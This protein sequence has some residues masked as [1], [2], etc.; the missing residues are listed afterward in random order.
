MRYDK[1][2]ATYISK[3][4]SMVPWGCEPQSMP[5]SPISSPR[6][7]SGDIWALRQSLVMAITASLEVLT[8]AQLVRL[9]ETIHACLAQELMEASSSLAS[10]PPTTL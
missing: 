3:Q 6:H 2:T 10:T 1:V 8:G 4:G 9:G 5:E 7:P